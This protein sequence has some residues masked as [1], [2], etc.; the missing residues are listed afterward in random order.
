MVDLWR[1]RNRPTIGP[2]PWKIYD[3]DEVETECLN[4][5]LIPF[6]LQFASLWPQIREFKPRLMHVKRVDSK[7]ELGQGLH[8]LLWFYTR[9]THIQGVTS[10]W[11]LNVVRCPSVWNLLHVTL[12][13]PRILRRALRFLENLFTACLRTHFHFNNAP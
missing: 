2:T 6:K 10:T 3:D 8:R 5:I 13:A 4:A 7:M 12:L 9:V 1:D 11:R